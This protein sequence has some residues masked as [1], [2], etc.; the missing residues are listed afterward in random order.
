MY[1][2]MSSGKD[3]R[4]DFDSATNPSSCATDVVRADPA[5]WSRER[6]SKMVQIKDIGLF[7]NFF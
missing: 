6:K 7:F 2:R 3:S 5:L 4:L 1:G